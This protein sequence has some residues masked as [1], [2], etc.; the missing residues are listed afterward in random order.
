MNVDQR[1]A[2]EAG[3][4]GSLREQ[5]AFLD[6]SAWLGRPDFFPLAEEIPVQG[7]PQ[8]LGEYGIRGALL[9]HWDGVRVSAQEGNQALLDAEPLLPPE[10]WTVWTGLPLAAGE[11]G[12]LPAAGRVPGRVRGV[13]LFPKSHHFSLAPWVVG[14]LCE[15]CAAHRLPVF[16]WHVE[17]DWGE[18]RALARAFPKLTI[19]VDSQWQKILY[20][21]RLLASLLA[22][23]ANVMVESSN[24][25]GQDFIAWIVRSWG[26]RRILYGSFLPANDPLS[27]MGMILDAGIS[28]ADKELIAGGNAR[29]LVGEVRP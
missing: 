13:R 9:S 27:A 3:A 2:E 1:I 4:R 23:C 16:V 7:L 15:W 22:D 11:Q 8:A 25:I 21:N 20:P 17:A 28:R 19:V 26:A 29:R 14:S 24:L 10:V 5:L 6:A 12:P 18:L